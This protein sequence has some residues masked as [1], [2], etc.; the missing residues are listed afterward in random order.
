MAYMYESSYD[1]SAGNLFIFGYACALAGF[2]FLAILVAL[3]YYTRRAIRRRWKKMGNGRRR[4]RAAE[5]MPN[6]T[7]TPTPTPTPTHRTSAAA[8]TSSSSKQ[9]HYSVNAGAGGRRR[10]TEQVVLPEEM[11]G[12]MF[13]LQNANR[14]GSSS[15]MTG[16]TTRRSMF[17]VKKEASSSSSTTA[18]GKARA[19]SAAGG[20]NG[21]GGDNAN[22][23]VPYMPRQSRKMSTWSTSSL[24][25][26][27]EAAQMARASEESSVLMESSS[28]ASL[29]EM[30][31]GRVMVGKDAVVGG[32]A[33][34]S[35]SPSIRSR[36]SGG[37]V[38]LV[39]ALPVHAPS[40]L[41]AE[42]TAAEGGAPS[43]N[44]QR[45]APRKLERSISLV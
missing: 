24:F 31:W 10:S 28:A 29:L 1:E 2:I 13:P 11:G 18:E 43:P 20:D 45:R 5:S 6:A 30:S 42:G 41:P 26:V 35:L 34:P 39:G 23:E 3:A 37:A 25:A 19:R 7:P 16:S 17:N 22:D 15:R 12:G 21:S 33:L 4:V 9:I 27:E 8:A 44:K 38:S 14:A 40:K 36:Q 32:V